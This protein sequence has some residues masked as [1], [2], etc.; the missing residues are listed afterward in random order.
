RVGSGE[1][2]KTDD[3]REPD[4]GEAAWVQSHRCG[5]SGRAGRK[6]LPHRT[7]EPPSCGIKTEVAEG[8]RIVDD[9]TRRGSKHG[10]GVESGRIARQ[11][12][13]GRNRGGRI[14][15]DDLLLPKQKRTP[16]ARIIAHH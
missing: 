2:S 8:G 12:R 10:R 4:C 6:T 14:R 16:S 1:A 9:S 15:T 13:V 3:V 7:L 5:R 11:E